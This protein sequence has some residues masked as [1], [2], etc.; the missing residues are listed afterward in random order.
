MDKEEALMT[1]AIGIHTC[2]Y[3]QKL[4]S[5]ADTVGSPS[6]ASVEPPAP[7]ETPFPQEPSNENFSAEHTDASELLREDE[8]AWVK[9]Y[10]EYMEHPMEDGKK[11]HICREIWCCGLRL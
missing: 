4:K 5:N 7:S 9:Q 10:D 2:G 3:I 1:N 8:E 11:R 6:P